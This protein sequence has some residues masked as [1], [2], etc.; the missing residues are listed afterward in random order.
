MEFVS[1]PKHPTPEMLKAA[2]KALF[3]PEA[4]DAILRA[5]THPGNKLQQVKMTLRWHAMVAAAPKPK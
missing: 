3:C 2:D 5:S 4:R 1:V